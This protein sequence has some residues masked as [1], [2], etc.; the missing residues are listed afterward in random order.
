MANKEITKLIDKDQLNLSTIASRVKFKRE[1]LKMKAN[2][3]AAKCGVPPTS[4]NMLEM[5]KV[6]QPQYLVKLADALETT[7]DF[8][9]R[10]DAEQNLV[11][12][13]KIKSQVTIDR[14][15]QP[16]P[17]ADYYLVKIKKG[18]TPFYSQGMTQIGKVE[19]ISIDQK[20]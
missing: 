1:S 4:I 19:A 6:R 12:A 7:T 9:L 2:V 5:G 20:L 17:N 8:L 15:I 3:L 16:D 10:G 11:Q 14:E 13:S 18:E